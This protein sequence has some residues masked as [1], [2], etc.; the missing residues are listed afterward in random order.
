MRFA[1][2]ILTL[3]IS[4]GPAQAGEPCRLSEDQRSVTI[5]VSNPFPLQVS[6]NMTCKYRRP[7]GGSASVSCKNMVPARAKDFV[8]CTRTGW[9]HQDD[10]E[11]H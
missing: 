1:E 11:I 9:D 3:L 8:L 6:Y 4:L 10:S 5:V 7:D 2:A